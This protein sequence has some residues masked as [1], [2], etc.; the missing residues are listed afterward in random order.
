MDVAPLT[1][2]DVDAA[3]DTITQ[4]F[5]RDPV[6]SV[7]LAG[8]RWTDEH[9]RSYWRL[10]VEGG[11]RYGTVHVSPGAM[12][13]SIWIPPGG[14]ELSPEL[15]AAQH[16]LVADGLEPDQVA[17]LHEL[18]ARFEQHH[19]YGEP[20]A[21]LG[22][23]A[24]RPDHAGHGYGQAHLAMDLAGWDAAGVPSYLESSNPVNLHRYE[25][26]GYRAIGQFATVLD[27]A[28]VTTMWRPPAGS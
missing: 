16:Q 9:L 24:T 26:H 18:W 3:V 27:G 10:F 8:P 21:Y 22:I 17:A 25:R 12:T 6:W 5:K 15:E 20:H 28:I 23:L 1:S 11:L 13:V 19:P 4:A 14:T 2:G 7:A